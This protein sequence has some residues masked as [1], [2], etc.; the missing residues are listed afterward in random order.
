MFRI[1][2]P[3]ARSALVLAGLFAGSLPALAAPPTQ[4]E[5]LLRLERL[6]ARNTQLEEE[7][8]ALKQES[9]VPDERRSKDVAA[10][11]APAAQPVEEEAQAMGGAKTVAGKPEGISVEAAVT[12]VWQKANGLPHGTDSDDKFNYRADLA[13]EVP[14]E[15]TGTIGHKLFA[16]A[17]VGQVQGQNETFGLLGHLNVPNSA[18]FQASGANADDS[19]FILAQAWYQA[20]IPVGGGSSKQRL[21]LTFGKIDVF[22]FF[23]QNE[24]AGDEATQFLNA[25]F[26]HNPLLDAGG[27]VGADANGFQPGVIASYLNEKNAEEP[28]RL[29]LGVFA[30]GDTASNYQ[31]TADSP[32]IIAQAEKT[33]KLFGER[34]GNYRLYG[35]TRGHVPR[36]TDATSERHT[37][38]GLSIDQEL[39]EG[40]KVFGRYGQ[41]VSGKLPT[42]RALAVGTEVSGNYWGRPED[43]VGVAGS[44]LWASKAYKRAGGVGYL[45]Q[46]SFE[47][48]VPDF[49]FTPSGAEQVAEIYYRFN[50]TR[51]FSL[52]PDFQWIRR[53]GANGHADSVKVIGVRA[54]IAY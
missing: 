24:A 22:G 11:V 30:A 17:R 19:N 8:R 12:T 37:G 14:L 44:W 2:P 27:E 32:L 50:L 7:V 43:S 15:S 48:G 9:D 41:L 53:G 5:L 39:S 54:N 35:W 36:F 25:V 23:D 6:E 29:S 26:V 45:S 1:T 16:H 42:K 34:T 4:E 51:Q 10:E 18:A 13:V 38:F 49:E 3:V 33:F 40:V 31:D 47:A 21:D 28:W 46:E 20:G 52:S